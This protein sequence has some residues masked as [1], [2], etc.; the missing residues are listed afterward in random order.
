MPYIYFGID[1][2]N[3]VLGVYKKNQEKFKVLFWF[4]KKIRQIN[5][6][7][8]SSVSRKIHVAEKRENISKMLSCCD[9][10]NFF[11]RPK[12]NHSTHSIHENTSK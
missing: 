2:I 10:T 9:L 11:P 5:V 1:Q 12:L 6:Q 7:K 4:L 3:C 8:Y